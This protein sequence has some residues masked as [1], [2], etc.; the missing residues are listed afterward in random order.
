MTA[1]SEAVV[2][3]A[4][5]LDVVQCK[6]VVVRD[7]LVNHDTTPESGPSCNI[8]RGSTCAI[9]RGP[10]GVLLEQCHY[11]YRQNDS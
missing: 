4:W 2:P 3:D 1:S 8:T 7:S 10:W 6:L 11:Y 9:R 5:R